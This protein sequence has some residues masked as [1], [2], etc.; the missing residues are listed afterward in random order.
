MNYKK[1]AYVYDQLMKDAP[2][3][4]WIKITEMLVKK[5][6]L[7]PSQII[8]LGCGT[9]NIA[10]P[11]SKQGYQ[12]IGVDLSEEMLSIAFDKMLESH[13]SFPL[14][15][16]NMMELDIDQKVGLII[17]YCDS[18]NY[19]HGIEEVKKAFIQVNKHL[20]DGAYFIFDM[21]SPYK[22]REVFH[23]QTFAWNDE[24]ISVIWQTEVDID[25]LMVNHD[26]TFFV[27]QS[28]RCYEKFQETHIQQTY[29]MEMVKQGLEET[30]FELEEV[31][32]DFQLQPVQENTERIFYVARK[33]S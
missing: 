1:F 5:Y 11:L 3:D 4:Q 33:Q 22:F 29:S 19:L 28:E 18:F 12:M 8:D 7:H 2:Y 9:G 15:Q 24:D 17:S 25:Q 30:G 26:L 27:K 16:Q 14:I 6:N 13:V 10:I 31:F 20:E 21:H 32:G 23:G